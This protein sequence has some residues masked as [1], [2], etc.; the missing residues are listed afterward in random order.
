[1]TAVRETSGDVK[2]EDGSVAIVRTAAI[3]LV[4][5]VRQVISSMDHNSHSE[6]NSCSASRE[7]PYALRKESST[8]LITPARPFTEPNNFFSKLCI[9]V[10]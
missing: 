4:H 2:G 6:A 5:A 1:M 7:I 9:K 8:A 3:G 10:L